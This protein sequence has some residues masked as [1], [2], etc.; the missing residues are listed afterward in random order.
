MQIMVT[1]TNCK[2]I[3]F[4][5]NTVNIATHSIRWQI[6]TANTWFNINTEN[7]CITWHILIISRSFYVRLYFGYQVEHLLSN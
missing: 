3:I 6:K 1:H 7:R 5:T 4:N 2:N